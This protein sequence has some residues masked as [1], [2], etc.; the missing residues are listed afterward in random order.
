MSNPN[1]DSADC[2]TRVNKDRRDVTTVLTDGS[3]MVN[4]TMLGPFSRQV[5]LKIFGSI[6]LR[7]A[8]EEVVE[9]ADRVFH[10]TIWRSSNLKLKTSPTEMRKLTTGRL[11]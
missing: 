2:R 3:Y 11:L 8:L 9:I 10:E 1:V 6:S 7:L 5:P 4:S